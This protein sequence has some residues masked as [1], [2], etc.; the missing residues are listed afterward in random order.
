MDLPDIQHL[1]KAVWIGA[2]GIGGGAVA[3]KVWKNRAKGDDDTQSSTEVLQPGI[4]SSLVNSQDYPITGT[5]P[6]ISPVV[7][8]GNSESGS[9]TD[10]GALQATYLDAV[11][12]LFGAYENL[13][14]PMQSTQQSLLLGQND[15]LLSIISA[16]GAPGVGAS[17][18]ASPV[19]SAPPP[20]T[21]T[22]TPIPSGATDPVVS[23]VYEN[24]TRDNGKR[25]A[26]RSVWCA[27]VKINVHRSGK[28]VAVSETKIKNGAC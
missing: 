24:R 5:S 12:G 19:V 16:G 18:N 14:G 23:V 6:L 8:T 13:V 3:I 1:P 28:R 27:K 4:D 10:T 22:A 26:A 7:L 15:A 21:P 17:S 2:L 9:G 20:A 25:G 11:G